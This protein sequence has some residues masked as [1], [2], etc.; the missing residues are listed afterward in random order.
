MISETQVK[1]YCNEDPSLIENYWDAMNDETQVWHC[2]HGRLGKHLSEE[3]KKKI[4]TYWAKRRAN[5]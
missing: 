3:T 2:H 5:Q 1:K 4:K